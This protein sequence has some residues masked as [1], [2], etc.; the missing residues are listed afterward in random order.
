MSND[1]LLSILGAP[2]KQ[3]RDIKEGEEVQT[4]LVRGGGEGEGWGGSSWWYGG[5]FWRAGGLGGG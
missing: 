5:G 2:P 1:G 4:S 3:K